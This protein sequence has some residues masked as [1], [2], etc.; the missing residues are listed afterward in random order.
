[1]KIDEAIAPKHRG[2]DPATAPTAL[3]VRYS[4][5]LTKTGYIHTNATRHSYQCYASKILVR[6][7]SQVYRTLQRT[8]PKYPMI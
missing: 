2:F 1:T 7:S 6:A 3:D 5:G 8:R 4:P